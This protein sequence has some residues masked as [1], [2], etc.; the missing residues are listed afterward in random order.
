MPG[1]EISEK[2]TQDLSSLVQGCR[3]VLTELDAILNAYKSPA[4]KS[5]GLSA[6]SQRAWNKINWDQE[7]IREFRDRITSNTTLLNAFTTSLDR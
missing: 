2:Q 4:T 5:H 6:R 7:K 3:D 1:R